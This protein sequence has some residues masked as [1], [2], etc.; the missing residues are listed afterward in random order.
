M[1]SRHRGLE[2]VIKPSGASKPLDCRSYFGIQ[3]IESVDVDD[4]AASGY[5]AIDFQLT[6]SPVLRMPQLQ[7]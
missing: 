6:F 2:V 1:Q 4:I 7:D 3:K 5:H